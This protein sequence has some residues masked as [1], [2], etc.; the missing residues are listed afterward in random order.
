VQPKPRWG[1]WSPQFHSFVF[2]PGTPLERDFK[3]A[4]RTVRTLVHI[5]ASR[6]LGDTARHLEQAL[7]EA[8][9][10]KPTA[11]ETAR[12]L[13]DALPPLNQRNIIATYMSITACDNL[14]KELLAELTGG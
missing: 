3:L 7:A 12:I 9:H 4:L 11:L 1:P 5:M 6:H 10:G 13:F 14:D 2:E 8:E